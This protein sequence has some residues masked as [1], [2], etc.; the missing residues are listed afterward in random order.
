[1]EAEPPPPPVVQMPPSP[2]PQ[3][4]PLPNPVTPDST[5]SVNHPIDP[6]KV[7]GETKVRPLLFFS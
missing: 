4:V 3:Y 2:L 7:R 5:G 1:M 6:E